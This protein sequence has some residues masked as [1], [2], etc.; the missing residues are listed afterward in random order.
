MTDSRTKFWY[1]LSK[2]DA[3]TLRKLSTFLKEPRGEDHTR[4]YETCC[5]RLRA[6]TR[7]KSG[8]VPRVVGDWRRAAFRVRPGDPAPRR[9]R[10]NGRHEEASFPSVACLRTSSPPSPQA[11]AQISGCGGSCRQSVTAESASGTRPAAV[12]AVT[13]APTSQGRFGGQHKGP[14]PSGKMS[15]LTLC[16]F[17]KKFGN[18][19]RRCAPG[20]SRWGED[21]PRNNPTTRVFQV[22][23]DLDGE[24]AGIGAAS[25]N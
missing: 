14:R 24:D 7:A 23:Q 5:A 21:R 10:D 18:S 3:A 15:T 22:E 13:K 19:A 17:H 11:L 1:V 4:S 25:E 8:C 16:H 12:S 6:E 9:K 2:F 20:C